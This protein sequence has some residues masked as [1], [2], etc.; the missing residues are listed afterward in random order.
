[1][2]RKFSFGSSGSPPQ[3]K[4]VLIN[5]LV[6]VKVVFVCHV[7]MFGTNL[8]ANVEKLRRHRFSKSY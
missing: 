3:R 1:M 5:G 4:T 8:S 6:A 2:F 7:M